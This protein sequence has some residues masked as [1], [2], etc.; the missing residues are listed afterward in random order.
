MLE[1]WAVRLI[2]VA[3]DGSC[4]F[5]SVA[6]ALNSSVEAWKNNEALTERLRNHWHAYANLGLESPDNF[7]PRLVRYMASASIDEDDLVAH[8]DV[9]RADGKPTFDSAG[10]LAEHVLHSDCWVDS[11]TFG[12]F[13]KSLGCSVAVVV[14]DQQIRQPLHVFDD[15]TKDKDLYILLW[16]DADHYQPMQIVHKDQ[17]LGT[18]VSRK[19]VKRFMKDCYPKLKERF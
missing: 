2:P 19:T 18:C 13:L 6:I 12:A 3:P 7:T 5:S 4:F 9:A 17:E 1:D 11:T 14:L 8:N 10:D 16:L 15:L